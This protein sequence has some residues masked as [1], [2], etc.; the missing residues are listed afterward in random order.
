MAGLALISAVQ[1]LN[2]SGY[3]AL[4]ATE[5]GSGYAP[6]V[7][8]KSVDSTGKVTYSTTWPEDTVAI[9]EV[10]I[11]P[12]PSDE[13]VEDTRHRHEKIRETAQALT[14]AREKRA[15][16]RE[17]E[18]KKRLENLALRRSA[19]PQ[20]YERKVYVG[21]NPLW[22]LHPPVAHYGKYPHKYPSHPLRRPGLSRGI[23]L[24]T[25]TSLR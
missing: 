13:Y 23:P 24:R 11:K 20:V 25:G 18:E 17:E 6:A 5:Y 14:E 1:S 7:V 16:K 10:A 2:A 8:Y 21:W 15:A 12:G 9:E 22:R 3:K 19:R 4:Y